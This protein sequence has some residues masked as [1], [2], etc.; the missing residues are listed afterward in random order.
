MEAPAR[1]TATFPQNLEQRIFIAYFLG[2]AVPLVTLGVLIA[3]H[4]LTASSDRNSVMPLGGMVYPIALLSLS[5]F[6]ML[7]RSVYRFAGPMRE[8]DRRLASLLSASRSFADAH[9]EYSAVE[10]A[11][12]SALALTNARV[13][14]M[15]LRSKG[16][17][18]LK[19]SA[20]AEG[21][22]AG[23]YEALIEPL[24]T[25]ADRVMTE[26]FPLIQGQ[27]TELEE[28]VHPAIEAAVILPLP[29]E[30]APLGALAV[31]HT[32][33]GSGFDAHDVDA[34][35][36]LAGLASVAFI[37]AELRLA[38][39]NFLSH[40]T[41]I[42]VTAVDVHLGYHQGHGRRVAHLARHVGLHLSLDDERLQQL[43]FAALLHD[44]GMLRVDRSLCHD[45]KSCQK[46]PIYG[47]RMLKGIVLW[48][49]VAAP[50]LH[51]HERFDGTGYPEGLAG[52][53]IPL[54]SRIIGLCEAFDT[55][56]AVTS[57]KRPVPFEVAAREI[58]AGAGSQFDPVVVRAFLELFDRGATVAHPPADTSRVPVR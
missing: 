24:I 23:L 54:G 32:N 48:H 52:E 17:D 45:A 11:V 5:C 31:I 53:A 26:E 40:M 39:R 14:C 4:K 22:E 18:S 27:G 2:A 46:H 49:D 58:G 43:Y 1:S 9:H 15:L 30:K 37:N 29:G 33:P 38:Q 50:V 28:P 12:H 47:W 35:T 16:D 55:M 21:D 51:H 13:A 41:D 34:L 8:H 6:F 57:Y 20:A 44:I 36:T 19:M 42:L 25:L 3:L 56:T 10:T 7:R